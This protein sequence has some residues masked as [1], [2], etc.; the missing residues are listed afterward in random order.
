M[1]ADAKLFGSYYLSEESGGQTSEIEGIATAMNAYNVTRN[2]MLIERGTVADNAWSRLRGLIGHRPL[3]AGEGLMIRPCN[4]VHTF[5][6]SFPIDVVYV[7]DSGEV[8][9]LAQRLTPNRVGPIVRKAS[10]VLEL[11]AGTIE[12]TATQ[13]EDRLVTTY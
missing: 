1:G 13:L 5:F 4:S 10:F 9:G 6:M 2:Q 8:V 11:P 7:S 3:E 12:D